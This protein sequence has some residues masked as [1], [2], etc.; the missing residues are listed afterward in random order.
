MGLVLSE[1]FTVRIHAPE[2]NA[3]DWGYWD[4]VV[5]WCLEQYGVPG[6]RFMTTATSDYMDFMFEDSRDAVHFSLRWS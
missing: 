2:G 6:K 4:D 3:G 5:A 1:K